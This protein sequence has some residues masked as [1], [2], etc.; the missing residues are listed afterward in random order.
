MNKRLYSALFEHTVKGD[1]IL[2][3]CAGM[4]PEMAMRDAVCLF[5]KTERATLASIGI[6]EG[7]IM[8]IPTGPQRSR[9]ISNAFTPAARDIDLQ[10]AMSSMLDWSRTSKNSFVACIEPPEELQSVIATHTIEVTQSLGTWWLSDSRYTGERDFLLI[11]Y[12]VAAGN[13][14]LAK[15]HDDIRNYLLQQADQEQPE[16]A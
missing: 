6:F 5:D 3:L 1:H 14:S 15:T 12:A 4:T 7:T 2:V 11:E 16:Y 8:N 13:E 10:N 9:R